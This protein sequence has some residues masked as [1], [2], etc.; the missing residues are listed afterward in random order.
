MCAVF[1]SA[2]RAALPHARLV[3]DHFYVVETNTYAPAMAWCGRAYLSRA[4]IRR[5]RTG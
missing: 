5:A 1:K 4:S 3:V 2:V